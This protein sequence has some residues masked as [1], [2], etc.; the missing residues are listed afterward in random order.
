MF[1][2]KF[3]GSPA[4]NVFDGKIKNNK[5][6]INNKI[7]DSK[8]YEGKDDLDL[9]SEDAYEAFKK[10]G[11]NGEYND[12]LKVVYNYDEENVKNTETVE[13][14]TEDTQSPKVYEK[15][16]PVVDLEIQNDIIQKFVDK[17]PILNVESINDALNNQNVSEKEY[18]KRGL[19]EKM[20]ERLK[21]V[22]DKNNKNKT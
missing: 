8:G 19:S 12:F 22:Y 1:V 6:Y 17:N 9:G 18:L 15:G 11:F 16:E 2:A 20:Y 3:L 13:A 14:T 4:I 10:V 5:L 21:K 7:L